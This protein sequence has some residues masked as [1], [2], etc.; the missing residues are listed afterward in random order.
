MRSLTE[1]V[2]HFKRGGRLGKI[3][4][5][6]LHA[7][8]KVKGGWRFS[9]IREGGGAGLFETMVREAEDRRQANDIKGEGRL[10]LCNKPSLNSL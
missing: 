7:R 3:A 1:R 4:L 8:E 6:R 5:G 2:S 9:F 10:D